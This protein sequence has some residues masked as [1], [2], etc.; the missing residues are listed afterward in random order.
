[1]PDDGSTVSHRIDTGVL[2]A[3]MP[4]LLGDRKSLPPKLFYDDEGCRLFG[5][6]TALPEYYLTRT[7]RRLLDEIAPAIA[8]LC[9]PGCALVEYG[10]SDEGKAEFLLRQRNPSGKPAFTDYV[11]ID[12]AEAALRQV[13]RRLRVSH[14]YLRVHPTAADFLLPVS[15][16]AKLAGTPRLGFFPGSTIGNLEPGEAKRFL[17]QIRRSLGDGARLLVGVDL[18]KDTARLLPA[19]NDASGVTADFN[20]NILARLNREAGADFDL[21]A[22]SH[23]AV[24]NDAES[25]IEMHLV[26]ARAQAVRVGGH[27]ITFRA[28]ETIHTENS[29][30]W[31]VDDFVGLAGQAGWSS[32]QVWKDP[33]ALFSVHLLEIARAAEGG[34]RKVGRAS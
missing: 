20:L 32:M 30:K 12:V 2:S 17:R 28:G 13:A 8:A 31:T 6:I 19:Y 10:A 18:R 21:S 14:A 9:P 24:W 29:Y 26:S 1:M 33:E 4:G 5:D 11:P 16:P 34:E 22:F 15:L 25:R 27:R 23:T 7:E 3:A